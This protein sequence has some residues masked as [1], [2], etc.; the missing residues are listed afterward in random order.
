MPLVTSLPTYPDSERGAHHAG[1][2]DRELYQAMLISGR[3]GF[4]VSFI[5]CDEDEFVWHGDAFP[6]H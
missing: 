4:I 2:V 3:I 1:G 5:C 6:I